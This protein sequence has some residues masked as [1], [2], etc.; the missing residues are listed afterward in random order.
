MDAIKITANRYVINT[1]YNFSDCLELCKN[2]KGKKF[3][4]AMFNGE[5]VSG[6][7]RV[8]LSGSNYCTLSKIA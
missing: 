5:T 3:L 4:I 6:Q 8:L 2:K 7:W 1:C